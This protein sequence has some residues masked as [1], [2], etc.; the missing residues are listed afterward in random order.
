LL[1]VLEE[2]MADVLKPEFKIFFRFAKENCCNYS[3]KGPLGKKHYCW[4]GPPKTNSLCVIPFGHSCRWFAEA[5]LPLDKALQAEWQRLRQLKSDPNAAPWAKRERVCPCGTRFIP[6]SNR[7]LR[8]EDCGK[9][10]R[11]E[12]L[13]KAVRKHRAKQV[14]P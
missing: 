7:Q 8:C 6:K 3:L 13:R 5:V 14:R 2:L 9:V 11:Q 12:L 10:H 1:V 4:L